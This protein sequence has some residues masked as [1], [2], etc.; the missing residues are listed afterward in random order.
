MKMC[1]LIP[2]A[3]CACLLTLP[4]H[5]QPPHLAQ[6][7]QLVAALVSNPANVNRYGTTTVNPQNGTSAHIDW[8]AGSPGA[9]SECST[10]LT[11]LLEHSY[12]YSQAV[13]QS[14]TGHASPTAAVYHDNIV[15]ARGFQPV[16]GP[17]FLQPGDTMAVKYPAGSES[18]GHVM[19]VVS[20]ASWHSR[21]DSTQTFLANNAHPE[22]AGFYDV[23]VIDSS[24]S[25]HG[26]ADTRASRPGGIGQGVIRVYADASL[27]L[28]GYTWSTLDSSEYESAA[29]GYLAA[30]GRWIP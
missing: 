23:T 30:L 24:S 12:G 11:L 19:T 21:A 15:A 7:Q 6:A 13:F 4:V 3:L 18:T 16:P 27:A 28:T 17:A 5:A 22:I 2:A 14:I 9:V 26:P 10:F 25:F 20:I 1:K 8:P 29:A